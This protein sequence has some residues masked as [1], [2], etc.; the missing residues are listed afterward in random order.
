[1]RIV[2]LSDTHTY[3]DPIKVPDGDMLI[4]CGDSTINGE[5][6]EMKKFLDWFSSHPHKHKVF[7]NG[8]HEKVVER[9]GIMKELAAE[10]WDLVYLEHETKEV[11][12]FKIFGSPHTPE[13]FDWAYMYRKQQGGLVWSMIPYDADIVITHGPPYGILDTTNYL[14]DGEDPHVGCPYLWSKI[15]LVKPKLHC[16]GHIHP[17]YGWAKV[18]HPTN[19]TLFVNASNCDSAYVPRHK[20]IVVDTD[21]WEVVEQG[22]AEID[23]D[24]QMKGRMKQLELD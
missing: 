19:P 1:M 6:W 21:T 12:G 11:A 9:M 18:N 10:R 20:P 15:Q 3:H 5:T 23:P 16:F 13:F 17:A 24:L 8:N 22:Q 14:R 7:I 2:I 4:H